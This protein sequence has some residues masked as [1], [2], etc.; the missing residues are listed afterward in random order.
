[1]TEREEKKDG[2]DSKSEEILDS[3]GTSFKETQ[4]KKYA[5]WP[6]RDIKE[7]HDNDVL[8]GRGGE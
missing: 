6:I 5:D 4:K 8:Y 1:M 2:D 7:P 3:K